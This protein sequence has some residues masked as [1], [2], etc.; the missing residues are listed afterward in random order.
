[1]PESAGVVGGKQNMQW[2]ELVLGRSDGYWEGQAAVAADRFPKKLRAGF[3]SLTDWHGLCG[4]LLLFSNGLAQPMPLV[5]AWVHFNP[6]RRENVA[7]KL[8]TP[9]NYSTTRASHFS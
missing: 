6:V 5:G 3:I 8:L 4:W 7:M 1:M 9:D 2:V